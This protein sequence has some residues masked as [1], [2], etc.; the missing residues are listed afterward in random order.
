MVWATEV[1]LNWC[2]KIPYFH[3][4]YQF[5]GCKNLIICMMLSLLMVRSISSS[6]ATALHPLNPITCHASFFV[7]KS[8]SKIFLLQYIMS[9]V[10]LIISLYRSSHHFSFLSSG[11][12]RETKSLYHHQIGDPFSAVLLTIDTANNRSN[13][14]RVRR[15]FAA[16]ANS[17][18]VFLREVL[19]RWTWSVPLTYLN[20]RLHRLQPQ[21]NHHLPTL[22]INN[23]PKDEFNS[24]SSSSSLSL[25]PTIPPRSV[26]SW[27]TMI[28]AILFAALRLQCVLQASCSSYSSSSSWSFF[29][30]LCRPVL[31]LLCRR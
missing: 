4:L 3:C 1:L 20:P 5:V 24:S 31:L 13:M 8:Q 19:T 12:E 2:L 30:S 6:T 29:R 16:A 7:F 17:G 9:L 10:I 27:V 11:R 14:E 21:Q 23:D 28:Y 22:G 15:D 26:S 18:R 25:S